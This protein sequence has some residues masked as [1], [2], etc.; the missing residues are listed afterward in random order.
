MTENRETPDKEVGHS[1][2]A[3]N[4]E[5]ID[6][7]PNADYTDNGYAKA[8]NQ[9]NEASLEVDKNDQ[10][11]DSFFEQKLDAGLINDANSAV[12]HSENNESQA[13]DD[14]SQ[15]PVNFINELEE[16]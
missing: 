2:R 4:F 16:F 10:S 9:K 5:G 13:V 3:A 6:D 11:L 7:T 1:D 8:S 12:I 15:V 14:S